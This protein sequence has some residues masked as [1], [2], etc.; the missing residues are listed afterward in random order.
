[1][2]QD[3]RSFMAGVEANHRPKLWYGSSDWLHL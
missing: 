2:A 1:L 3:N